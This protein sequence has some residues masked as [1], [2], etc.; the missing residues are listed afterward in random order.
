M[1]FANELLPESNELDDTQPAGSPTHRWFLIGAF[2]WSNNAQ[3]EGCKAFP[4]SWQGVD[5]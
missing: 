1:D 2:P 3:T 5:G 4:T